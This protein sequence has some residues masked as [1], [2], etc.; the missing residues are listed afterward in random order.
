M[1]A[2]AALKPRALYFE[3]MITDPWFYAVAV[4]AVLLAAIGKGGFGGSLGVISVPMLALAVSPLQAAAIMLPVL[5]L[6]DLFAVWTYRG[7]W[8]RANMRIILPA[9][10]VGIALGTLTAGL[11]SDHAIRFMVGAIAVIFAL[12]HWFGRHDAPPAQPNWIK[13][14]FWSVVGA[15]T[16]FLAH[17]GGPPLNLYMLP[18]RLD[19]A[20]FVGT[21]VIYWTIIN[22]VK[23]VPYAWLGQFD[24]ATLLTALL[25]A[26]LTPLGVWIGMRINRWLAPAR[27]FSACYALVF[28]LGLKLLWDSVR[29]WLA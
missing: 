23:L 10:L 11:L 6:S 26:P 28:L 15:Y 29:G 16:S 24:R 21:V 3:S 1:N 19:K 17:A 2:R 12:D 25:L 7:H 4:P 13:G 22:Y 9:G 18:Q 27:F 5:C 8:D 20:V 14:S